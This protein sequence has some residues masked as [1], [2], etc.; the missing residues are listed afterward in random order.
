[1][2]W[3]LKA[4]IRISPAAAAAAAAM[5][6]CLC[7]A[8]AATAADALTSCYKKS[9]TTVEVQ[10]CLKEE[11]EVVK[12]RYDDVVERVM[13]NA[14]ELDRVQKKKTAANAF[15]EANKAFEKFV[16]AECGWINASY[17][18]GTGA[19]NAKLACRIN[20][21]RLR[22]GAMDAQFLTPNN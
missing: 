6:A 11:L 12:K 10:A 19:G 9:E 16:D 5:A 21:M 3:E 4:M 14:R 13:D 15:T 17:G 2:F 1:M 22:T 20:L 8:S 7:V 18:S